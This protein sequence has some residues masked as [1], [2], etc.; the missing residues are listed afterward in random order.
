MVDASF[1]NTLAVSPVLKASIVFLQCAPVV[2]SH[3][4]FPNALSKTVMVVLEWCW[5]WGDST[6]GG[7]VN[8]WAI[9]LSFLKLMAKEPKSV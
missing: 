5:E 3:L 9:F 8:P 7:G 2:L 1:F 4:N 6:Q